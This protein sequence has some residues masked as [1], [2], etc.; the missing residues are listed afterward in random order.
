MHEAMQAMSERG[1]RRRR[2]ISWVLL[3]G[4]G[5]GFAFCIGA[6]TATASPREATV[7]GLEALATRANSNSV[8]VR[9]NDG[10]STALR[11]G[12][13]I[14]YRFE[15][16]QSGYLTAIHVDTHGSAT[17]LY[18]GAGDGSGRVEAG[19]AVSFPDADDDF[20]LEVEPPTGRDVVYAFVTDAP[21]DRAQ[22]GLESDDLVVAFEP[23]QAPA[24]I[25]RLAVV[26]G[27]RGAAAYRANK[28]T[29]Q[30][31][32]RGAVQYRS[33]DIANYFGERTR[34]IAPAKLDLQ[35]QFSTNS[36]VLDDTAKRNID[37]FAEALGDPRLKSMRFAVAGH[38]DERGSEKHNAGLS[39]Q[40][41]ESVHNYLIESDGIDPD[42]LAI[43]AYGE[44]I[45]LI[46]EDSEYARRM[47]RRVE[48]MPIRD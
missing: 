33:I 47:N 8:R 22:L 1:M 40:R 23:Q 27:E 26:L 15:S 44:M 9:V 38:T 36:A 32:G 46:E 21:V 17:L 14:V 34:S 43:E 4:V 5:V 11:I 12:D 2:S 16:D 10:A 30:I 25:E 41:A 6:G 42:R 19:K 24:F 37:E 39:R 3:L 28:L 35:I 18:P 13:E 45:P 7:A 29:Q 31:D 48:F 20:K